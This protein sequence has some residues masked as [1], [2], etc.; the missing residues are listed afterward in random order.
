M[1]D[2]LA[3]I[4]A[5]HDSAN[6]AEPWMSEVEYH[7]PLPV[8]AGTLRDVIASYKQTDIDRAWL[9]AEVERLNEQVRIL[10][11]QYQSYRE[12]V[13]AAPPV[14]NISAP[15]R[16]VSMMFAANRISELEAEV[17]R[18]RNHE[19][20]HCPTCECATPDTAPM[21]AGNADRR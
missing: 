9:I 13:S 15:D 10:D 12:A 7:V 4:K 3:E 21:E 1:S 17:E 19:P 6:E 16:S 11:G 5:R 8:P 18:L 14:F 2:R 20:P